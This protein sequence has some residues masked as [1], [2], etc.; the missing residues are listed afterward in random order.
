MSFQTFRSIKDTNKS[1]VFCIIDSTHQYPTAW[2]T[3]LVKNSADFE[4]ATLT[5]NGYDVLVGNDEDELLRIASVNGYSH[6]V[7]ALMGTIWG[8]YLDFYPLLDQKV[9]EDW[10]LM[11][12]ILDKKIAY[13]ELHPQCYVI[14]LEQYQRLGCP[15]IGGRTLY[16]DHDQIVPSRSE[17]NYHDDYTPLWVKS[18]NDRKTFEHKCHGWNILRLAFENNLSVLVFDEGFRNS[19]RYFYPD[20]GNPVQHQSKFYLETTV[21]ARHWINPF[22]TSSLPEYDLDGPLKNLITT[23]NGLDWIFYLKKYG[24]EQ[25]TRVKFVDY[26]MMFLEFTKRLLEWDGIDYIKFLETFGREKTEFLGLPSD[27]WYGVKTGVQERWEEFKQTVGWDSIWPEIKQKVS[28]EFCYKD[29]LHEEVGH[30]WIDPSYNDCNTLINLSHVFSYHSTAIFYT[31]VYRLQLENKTI[32]QLKHTV[33]D[34]WVILEN[35][36]YKGFKSYDKYS[37]FAQASDLITVDINELT[38]PIWHK[39]DW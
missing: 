37:K 39:N 1:T 38:K 5:G 26:N 20:D 28:F 13:Y 22:G 14:N 7:V 11:G 23:C 15:D 27:T 3:E 34:A 35:R 36:A 24:F 30:N 9:K 25:G 32:E 2:L 16:T 29:F 6:A 17:E 18:G 19:K 12:H 31:L 4:I 33:P 21:A 10:F 8:D